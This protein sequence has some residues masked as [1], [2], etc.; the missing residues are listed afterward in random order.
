M[1]LF[2]Q[3]VISRLVSLEENDHY[4]LVID[5]TSPNHQISEFALKNIILP[6][7]TGKKTK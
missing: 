5:E 6:E 7:L 3:S 2:E 4:Y 1:H